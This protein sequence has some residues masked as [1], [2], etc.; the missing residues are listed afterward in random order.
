MASHSGG[1][2]KRGRKATKKEIFLGVKLG[3]LGA[4]KWGHFMQRRKDSKRRFGGKMR[5]LTQK[6]GVGRAQ[7]RGVLG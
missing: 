7:K 6:T 2:K 4:K 3:D 1:V 5:D